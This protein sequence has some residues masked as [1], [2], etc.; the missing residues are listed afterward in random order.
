MI[1]DTETLLAIDVG[2]IHTVAALFDVVEGAYRYI[3]SAETRSTAFAPLKDISVGVRNAVQALQTITGRVFLGGDNQLIIPALQD[4]SGVDRCVVTLSAG[5][6]LKVVTVGLLEDVSLESAHRLV[7]TIYANVRENLSLSDTRK[8]STRLDAILR[9]Q[10]DLIVIA[11]GVDGGA[12]QSIM[13]LLEAVGLAC[14]LTPKELRPEILYAGNQRLVEQIKADLAS[15]APLEVAE[16]IRPELD[17][18]HLLPAQRQLADTYVRAR[19]RQMEGVQ[20]MHIW[21]GGNLQ[22]SSHA[23][24]RTMR[25]LSKQVSAYQRGVLGVDIGASATTLASA[26]DGQESLQV[27]ATLGLGTNLTG[28]LAGY[29][30]AEIQRWVDVDVSV[31]DIR[32]YIY[33]KAL[34]PGSIPADAT[35]LSIEFALASYAI[36]AAVKKHT[37]KVP[38]HVQGYIPGLLP[39][40]ETIIASG[41]LFGH[42]PSVGRTI[43]TLLNALQPVG[44]STL[45]LDRNR[46]ATMVGAAAQV[47]PLL[48]VQALHDASSFT[49]LGMVIAPVG[50]AAP[51]ARVLRCKVRYQ[52]G[53][54]NT[55]EF[56]Y[57]EIEVIPL[58]EGQ[59]A[60][61]HLQPLN[62]FDVGMGMPGRGGTVKNVPGN[63]IG[64]IVDTRGRPLKLAA[65]DE[66]RRAQLTKWLAAFDL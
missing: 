17:S 14:Y 31:N 53:S 13:A 20:A 27:N 43:L 45:L 19:S 39:P 65:N 64:I 11:G 4:G 63:G 9:L 28:L 16:N 60:T 32:N 35:D 33:N 10:P 52:D 41:A 44:W 51:G 54:E 24:A 15:Y 34:Y 46:V 49:N 47:L 61:L 2:T 23:F 66:E 21:S 26:F 3:A 59:T 18:E 6:P 1:T 30:L 62:R 36:Q 38:D 25:F 8:S 7:S 48:T 57:G 56:H 50:R 12:S 58:P 42:S 37:W 22:P 55:F 5:A 40:F 29:G